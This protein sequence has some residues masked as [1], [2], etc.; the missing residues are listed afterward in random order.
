MVEEQKEDMENL[1]ARVTSAENDV[2]I[3]GQDVGKTMTA[4][5]EIKGSVDQQ[6]TR[7]NELEDVVE[8]TVEKVD[9][10]DKKV[11]FYGLCNSYGIKKYTVFK[12]CQPTF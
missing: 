7:L 5:H 6:E 2:T 11:S 12:H 10:I 4:V 1:D 9:E 8:E 3:L